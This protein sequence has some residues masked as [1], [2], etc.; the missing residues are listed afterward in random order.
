MKNKI[1]ISLLLI[2][3]SKYC[4]SQLREEKLCDIDFSSKLFNYPYAV[5]YFIV[6]D[7][8]GGFYLTFDKDSHQTN[9]ILYHYNKNC[10]LYDSV[11]I[12]TSNGIH[13]ISINKSNKFLC[14]TNQKTKVEFDAYN[15]EIQFPKEKSKDKNFTYNSDKD[16][17]IS[18]DSTIIV[19]RKGSITAT[20]SNGNKMFV[21][22]HDNITPFYT[23]TL[24]FNSS[25]VLLKFG[26]EG[27][28]LYDIKNKVLTPASHLYDNLTKSLRWDFSSNP[29]CKFVIGISNIDNGKLTI[30]KYHIK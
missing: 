24:Y 11:M 13:D 26:R 9:Y 6:L 23:K 10:V 17:Y 21:I 2:L 12:F 28:F 8:T 18:I 1:L 25:F 4:F 19:T 29:Y 20:S 16:H 30:S 27:L 22:N 14:I 7:S 15:K 5:D 3:F